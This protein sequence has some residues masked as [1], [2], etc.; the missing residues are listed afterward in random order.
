ME[1]TGKNY[2]I[3]GGSSG[4]GLAT[5]QLALARDAGVEIIGRSADKLKAAAQ[6]LGSD[7]LVTTPLDMTDESAVRAFFASKPDASIDALV[8]SASNA[9]HGPFETAQ[10]ADIERMFASKF[11]GPFMLAREALPKLR[12]GGAITFFSGVLSRRPGRNGAG[13]TAVNAAVE[14]LSRALALELGPRLRVNTVSPGMAKTDAYA[15]MPDD[16]RDAMFK[17]VAAGLPVKRVADAADIAEAAIYLSTNRFT[18]GHVLDVDGGHLI[19][20]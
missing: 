4:I 5:A 16:Q 2:L 20:G 8:I 18:T 10:T 9:V 6:K 12:D 15:K 19:A 11:M 3:V 1:L 14:G 7:R 17:S 13:L